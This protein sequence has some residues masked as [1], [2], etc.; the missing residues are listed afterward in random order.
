[1]KPAAG[2]GKIGVGLAAMLV[3]GNM[4]G[5]G[6]YLLPAVLAGVGGI[7]ILGWGVAVVGALLLACMF[8][9][10]AGNG[11][12]ASGDQGLIGRIA[13][14][15]GPFWGYQAA[16]LYSVGCWVGNVA[17]ALAVTGYAASF[18]PVL[19]GGVGSAVFTIL[20][21]LL[22]TAFNIFGSGM[23]GRLQA[24]TLVIGLAPV[25]LIGV[26]GWAAFHPALFAAQWNVTGRSPA[27]AVGDTILPIFWAFLGLESAAVCA[28]RVRD[29]GRNIA[30]ATVIGVAM[31]GIVY[32]AS[33]V[34][35]LGIL[36]AKALAASTAPFADGAHAIL[37]LGVGAVVA[38]CAM[39]RATGTLA[40]WVLVTAETAQSAA[41]SGLFSRVLA[42]P[43]PKAT[44][45]TLLV[46]AVIMSAIVVASAAP[47]LS[48]QFAALIDAA[49]LVSLAMYILSAAA[50]WRLS[51][52][53]PDPRRRLFVRS[54][55]GLS[56]LFC[57]GVVLTT[58][59]VL[60]ALGFAVAALAALA[61]A[62][63]RVRKAEPA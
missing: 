26:A 1:M 2:D 29:P 6:V 46:A 40:G 48:Q 41:A 21:I 57:L 14:G 37:G 59:P 7:S 27:H 9:A 17:I 47:A 30:R 13:D 33:C 4:I 51:R 19:G 60:L 25:L 53:E 31:A 5:S 3:A 23:V 44:V 11:L 38:V 49:V 15:L 20:L 39:T 24:A 16:A 43:G 32:A 36:P 61:Y 50:L 28:V 45:R 58:K 56:I 12:E 10:F 34:V 54:V 55:A 52:D 42:R 22:V 18:A 62:L 63:A 35:L 8:A